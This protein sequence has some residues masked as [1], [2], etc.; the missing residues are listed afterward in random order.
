MVDAATWWA[1]LLL[2]VLM[3]GLGAMLFVLGYSTYRSAS[4]SWKNYAGLTS[5]VCGV[6][7]LIFGGGTGGAWAEGR[8]FKNFDFSLYFA[9]YV[10]GVVSVLVPIVLIHLFRARAWRP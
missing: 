10:F 9:P 5:A 2:G 6:P 8:M 1:T 4:V 7:V 3:G